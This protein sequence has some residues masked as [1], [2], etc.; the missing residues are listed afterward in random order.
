[1]GRFHQLLCLQKVMY[2]R[3]CCCQQNL[4]HCQKAV[5]GLH[6][7]TITRVYQE[8]FDVIVQMRT[9]NITNNY[10]RIDEVLKQNLVKLTKNFDILNVTNVLQLSEFKKL[11]ERFVVRDD[12]FT[13]ERYKVH[14][15]RLFQQ[16]QNLILTFTSN[17]NNN[18]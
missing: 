6:H 1:M 14:W 3:C 11:K 8:I 9:E 2:V 5:Y 17:V 12:S 7:N 18:C 16:P 15:Y 13:T 4:H 10:D